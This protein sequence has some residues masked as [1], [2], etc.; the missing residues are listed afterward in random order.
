MFFSMWNEKN[1]CLSWD[2]TVEYCAILDLKTVPVLYRGIWD[3]KKI[4]ELYNESKRDT[5][6]GYV[7]RTVDGFHYKDFGKH[8]A[9]FVRKNHVNPD[10]HHWF[11]T[12]IERNELK[13]SV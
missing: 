13:T 9:K 2:E 11:H 6:E 5:M 10:S 3:E 4:R 7:V 8:L 1:N 12:A